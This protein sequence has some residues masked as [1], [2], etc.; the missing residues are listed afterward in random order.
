M[1]KYIYDVCL[2]V[3]EALVYFP[4][5]IDWLSNKEQH[6]RLY[7]KK[8]KEYQIIIFTDITQKFIWF[9]EAETALVSSI[10]IFQFGRSVFNIS[11]I[12]T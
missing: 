9:M 2:A 1:R 6:E 5:K 10:N 7:S 3:Y 8:M 11:L 4:F 12:V